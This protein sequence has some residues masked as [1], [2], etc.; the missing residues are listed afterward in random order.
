MAVIKYPLILQGDFSFSSEVSEPQ[1]VAQL[2]GDQDQ[3]A[4]EDVDLEHGA[5]LPEGQGLSGD[6]AVFSGE[7]AE[8][9]NVDME[10]SL[11]DEIQEIAL[12]EDIDLT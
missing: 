11:S 5:A 1:Q 3:L 12:G 10:S 8:T 4:Q 9:I 2:S 6:V 7:V